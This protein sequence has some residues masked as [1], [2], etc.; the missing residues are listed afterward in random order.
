[1]YDSWYPIVMYQNR[2]EKA[3][4]AAFHD[5]AKALFCSEGFFR[6]L[7]PMEGAVEAVK[8]IVASGIEIKICTS[9]VAES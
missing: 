8:E 9:P 1:M 5:E 7:P 2:M 6:N 3:V 4:P